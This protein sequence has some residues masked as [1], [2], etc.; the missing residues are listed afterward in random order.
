MYYLPLSKDAYESARNHRHVSKE[1]LM[2]VYRNICDAILYRET[3]NELTNWAKKNTLNMLHLVRFINFCN[4]NYSRLVKDFR[5]VPHYETEYILGAYKNGYDY[6]GSIV[7]G[8]ITITIGDLV[9]MLDSEKPDSTRDP[10]LT[11]MPIPISSQHL[12]ENIVWYNR[13][14]YYELFQRKDYVYENIGG[15][16]FNLIAEYGN[17]P[18]DFWDEEYHEHVTKDDVDEFIHKFNEIVTDYSE[19]L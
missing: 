16:K 19:I 18:S 11:T 3:D 2:F 5:V 10:F 14:Y 15:T 6:S 4:E 17:N 1:N 13:M 9:I 8:K 12:K 7:G